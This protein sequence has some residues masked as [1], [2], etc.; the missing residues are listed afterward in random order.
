MYIYYSFHEKNM[1]NLTTNE[2]TK[3]SGMLWKTLTLALCGALAFGNISCGSTTQEDVR[4][5]EQ[6]IEGI[7][8]QLSSY[9]K[10]RKDL[11]E[12]YNKLLK[13]P[14]TESNKQDI[15]RSLSGIH[16]T[17]IEYDEKIREL[18]EDR[19]DATKTLNEYMAEVETFYAPNTPIDP[20]RWDFL[21]AIK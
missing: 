7:N 1:E 12:K 17:I 10:S 8:F 19:L 13:Y 6:E 2:T 11:V 16:E 18:G 5:Q 20:N 3:K 4:K 21:L 15:N 9:I 14:K